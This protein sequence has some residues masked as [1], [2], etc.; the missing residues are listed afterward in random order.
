MERFVRYINNIILQIVTTLL[1][2]YFEMEMDQG[3]SLVQTCT[4]IQTYFKILQLTWNGFIQRKWYIERI[5]RERNM[6]LLFLP[7]VVCIKELIL[8][9]K[10][11]QESTKINNK[12]Y[13]SRSLFLLKAHRKLKSPNGNKIAFLWCRAVTSFTARAFFRI[14]MLLWLKF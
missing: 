10:G 14:I 12:R 13:Q 3:F 4:E 9:L 5:H 6:K 7:E 11:T 1:M 8:W 2:Q